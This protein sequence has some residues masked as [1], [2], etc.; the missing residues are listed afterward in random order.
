MCHVDP[1]HTETHIHASNAGELV[2]L[3]NQPTV[4]FL[5]QIIQCFESQ[6][7]VRDIRNA[8]FNCCDLLN[9][10]WTGSGPYILMTGIFEFL[11]SNC[12]SMPLVL[13]AKSPYPHRDR[14]LQP[15]HH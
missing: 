6:R 9:E 14:Y 5:L 8:S 2:I 7:L 11:S 4:L 13:G 12:L 15:L 3:S 1:P 10:S